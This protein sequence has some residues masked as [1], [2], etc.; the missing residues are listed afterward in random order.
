MNNDKAV[1][2][3]SIL[4]SDIRLPIFRMLIQAGEKGLNPRYISDKLNIKPNKLSFHLNNMKKY[5]LVSSKKNGRELIYSTNYKTIQNLVDFLFKNC[6]MGD[7]K[8]CFDNDSM[9]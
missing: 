7:N 4:G 8:K 9:C 5:N 2:L 3:L 6:C 1:N